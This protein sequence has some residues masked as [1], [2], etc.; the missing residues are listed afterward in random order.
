MLNYF[1][2]VDGMQI[3]GIFDYCHLFKNIRNVVLRGE[4]SFNGV[5]VSVDPIKRIFEMDKKY[6]TKMMPKITE[7]HIAPN[8]FQKM[9]VSRAT[10]LLSHTVSAAVKTYLK[11]NPKVFS[12][13]PIEIVENVADFCGNYYN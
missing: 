3:F 4:I 7:A 11:I 9:T 1:L 6:S 13:I 12:N 10:Q 2:F 8:S 5:N